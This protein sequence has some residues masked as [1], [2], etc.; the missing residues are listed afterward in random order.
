M[1]TVKDSSNANG[2]CISNTFFPHKHIHQASWYPPG[3]TSKPSLKDYVL[4]K[5][6]MMPSVLD[7]RVH[8]GGDMDSD[9][10]LVVT[11]IRLRLTKKTRLLRRQ[12]FD[13]ELLL[14]DQRKADYMETIEKGPLWTSRRPMTLW[15]AQP[16]SPS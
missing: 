12:Q 8:R 11:P 13:V 16:L 9:Y 7:T 15:T 6:R 5:E 3:P 14:Q 1:T 2:M 4:I 10:Q